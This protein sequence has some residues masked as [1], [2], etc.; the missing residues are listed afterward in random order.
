MIKN[1]IGYED[2]VKNY[3]MNDTI[4]KLHRT[5]RQSPLIN[6]KEWEE[7]LGPMRKVTN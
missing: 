6:G 2:L 4:S 1:K 3:I 7:L 5:K